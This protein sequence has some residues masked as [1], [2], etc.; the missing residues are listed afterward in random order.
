MKRLNGKLCII[1]IELTINIIF[2]LKMEVSHKDLIVGNEYI[3]SQYNVLF[4]GTFCDQY[5]RYYKD[6]QTI[7]FRD[8]RELTVRDIKDIKDIKNIRY[9]K[10]TYTS[11]VNYNEKDKFYIK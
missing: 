10:D 4:I 3:I 9:K 6:I 7:I 5:Q 1:K 8:V 11:W 2:L